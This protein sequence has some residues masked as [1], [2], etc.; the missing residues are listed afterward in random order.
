MN[1]PFAGVSGGLK[2]ALVSRG[3]TVAGGEVSLLTLVSLSAMPTIMIIHGS[4]S[5]SVNFFM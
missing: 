3:A 5:D 2:V 4:L 1:R